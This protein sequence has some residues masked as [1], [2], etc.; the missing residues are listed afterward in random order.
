MTCIVSRVAKDEL[1][2]EVLTNDI[3]PEHDPGA[4]VFL[5]TPSHSLR[6]RGRVCKRCHVIYLPT[7]PSEQT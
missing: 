5:E 6:M 2:F 7:A 4:V 3:L 1:G